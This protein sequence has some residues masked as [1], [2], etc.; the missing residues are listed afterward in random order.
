MSKLRT[1]SSTLI[2]SLLLGNFCSAVN[3]SEV[4]KEQ[5]PVTVIEPKSKNT[6]AK[7]AKI[8]TEKFEIGVYLG[9]LSVEDFGT[10]QAMGISFL[11]HFSPTVFAQFS[12]GSS[13]VGR[14][15]FE[16]V[17]GQDFLS[18][19]DE[20]FSYTQIAAGYKL[21]HGRSFLGEKSKFNSHIYLTGGL[22][23]VEFAG[24]SNIGLVVGTTYKVVSTDWLT[25]N[26]EL[27]NHIFERDFLADKKMTNNIEF[28]VGFNVLF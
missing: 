12:Y 4:E 9:S 22:E 7:S 2:F 1:L 15:T 13:D 18:D 27:K 17:A 16:E 21:F 11:Y 23:N 14:A 10:N 26:F 20:V 5:S 8:D 28:S 3:A 25:W 24:E 6:R 19:D